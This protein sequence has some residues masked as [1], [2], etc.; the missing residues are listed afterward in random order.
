MTLLQGIS[1]TMKSAAASPSSE[2]FSR[3]AS[4]L[5][6][7]KARVREALQTATAKEISE[8][9]QKLGKREPL[10]PVEQ[11][12]VGFWVVGDAEGYTKMED[13]FNK[14]QEEFRRLGQ[15]L[16]SYESQ[17]PSPHN[18][19]EIHGVW[20]DAA[21][22]TADLTNFLEKKE[23]LARFQTAVTNLTPADADFLISLLKSMLTS[24]EM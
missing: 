2:E 14:W 11:E 3:V 10:T 4:S 1:Q 22:V 23:R 20:E 12:L 21:R 15:V 24:P 19:V 16:E 5:A 8:I 7:A 6:Q 17:P 18:L 9:L 13:D